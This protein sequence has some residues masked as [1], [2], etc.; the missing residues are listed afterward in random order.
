MTC[1]PGPLFAFR[2][3]VLP[4][5]F[6]EVAQCTGKAKRQRCYCRQEFAYGNSGIL[7]EPPRVSCAFFPLAMSRG[8]SLRTSIS[9]RC[10]PAGDLVSS[11]ATSFSSA[12]A[13]LR[14]H[15]SRLSSGGGLFL[16]HEPMDARRFPIAVH[17]RVPGSARFFST[18]GPRFKSCTGDTEGK[19]AIARH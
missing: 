2:K 9:L 8:I 5:Y 18:E 10:R 17:D 13:L 7:R 16:R 11:A 15:P 4:W 6:R 3:A 19:S 14:I 1:I 12:E